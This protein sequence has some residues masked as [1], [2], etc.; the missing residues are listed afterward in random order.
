[1]KNATVI[2]ATLAIAAT[3]RSISAVRMT[4][5][6]PVAMIAV[7]ETWRSTL[8][9]LSTVA[10]DGLKALNTATRK[11]SVIKGAMLVSWPASQVPQ[12]VGWR[13]GAASELQPPSSY[14]MLRRAGGPCS[15]SRS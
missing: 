11:T 1:M 15:P 7:I 12:P 4:K 8:A 2:P 9:R 6:R 13:R 10:K 14:L 5:V 3:E